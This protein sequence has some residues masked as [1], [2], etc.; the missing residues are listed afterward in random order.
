MIPPKER[1][2]EV[3]GDILDSGIITNN[4]PVVKR[5]EQELKDYTGSKHALTTANGTISLHMAIR[6]LGLKGEIITSPLTYVAS[7]S[8][9]LWE[10]CQPVFA[11]VDPETLCLDPEKVKEKINDNTVGILPVHIYGN[12]CD[13][14]ALE[15][16]AAAHGL[17]SIYD[18]AQAFGSKI[19]GKS[20]MVYGDACSLS[21]HAYKIVSSVEGGTIFCNDDALAEE[22]F[23]IRYFGKNI[24]NE[25]IQLGTNGKMSEL[26]A[27]FGSISLSMVD[28]E[29]AA[30]KRIYEF[31]LEELKDTGLQ[32]QKAAD[33][34]ELNY[35]YC[36]IVFRTEEDLVRVVATGRESGVGIRR[37]FYPSLSTMEFLGGGLPQEA[38]IAYDVSKRIAC[39]PL[40]SSLTDAETEKIVSFIKANM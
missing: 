17:R 33:N 10:G 8:C 23:K 28:D 11:D 35:A 26:N 19:N 6:A 34:V 4:G 39:L 16:L 9:I 36:P 5:F 15:G 38:P 37:Y 3:F 27:A 29:I 31:Y 22:I 24:N 30:R 40:Y 32:F 21:L 25:V 20:A 12:V 13:V 1:I 14:D 7:S 2:L 18:G